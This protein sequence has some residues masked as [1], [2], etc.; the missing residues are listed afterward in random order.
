MRTRLRNHLA[1]LLIA[2][3]TMAAVAACA[4]G[5]SIQGTW[6][7]VGD[8]GW[9]QAQ[10]GAVVQFGKDTANLYS[11]QDTYAFY[12]D[13]D[14]YRLDVTGVLGGTTSFEVNVL[15]DDNIELIEGKTLLELQRR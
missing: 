14:S 15:D 13:G 6:K 12:K 8:D 3:A 10:P 1:G 11:P 7:C 5:F 9:G 2:M 4:S